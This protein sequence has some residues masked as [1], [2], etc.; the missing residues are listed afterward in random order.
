M[1]DWVKF[2][3]IFAAT[4]I[5]ETLCS[6]FLILMSS[7]SMLTAR[8]AMLVA[9]LITGTGTWGMKGPN[10][11][12]KALLGGGKATD[13]G[14][15]GATGTITPGRGA[16][17]PGTIIGT[18]PTG[19][20][21]KGTGPNGRGIIGSL[22]RCKK[23]WGICSTGFGALYLILSN[24]S[25]EI[26]TDARYLSSMGAWAGARFACVGLFGPTIP[27]SATKDIL[28]SFTWAKIGPKRTLSPFVSG[29]NWHESESPSLRK[30][31][32]SAFKT[33]TPQ[34]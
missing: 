25:K 18:G 4:S 27:R 10:T 1:R 23:P 8:A 30:T 6:K 31:L 16:I 28:R 32:R 33:Q 2:F 15:V 9:R 34:T 20:M 26:P 5:S 22:I 12:G 19:L 3:A 29:L 13:S 7:D 24:S 11:P 21:P 17:W 14:L